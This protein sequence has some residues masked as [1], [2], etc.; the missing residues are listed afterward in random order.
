MGKGRD[1][2][3]VAHQLRGLARAHTLCLEGCVFSVG[4]NSRVC[5][6]HSKLFFSVPEVETVSLICKFMGG[7][8]G[9]GGSDGCGEQMEKAQGK[10]NGFKE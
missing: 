9:M 4:L 5:A 7:G 8:V 3:A 6:L 1:P 2:E 10:C